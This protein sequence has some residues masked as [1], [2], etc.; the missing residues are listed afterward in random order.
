MNE[1]SRKLSAASVLRVVIERVERI[2]KDAAAVKQIL[3]KMV[4]KSTQD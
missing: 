1:G 3:Q 4:E 2:E